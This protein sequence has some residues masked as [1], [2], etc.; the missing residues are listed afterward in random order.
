MASDPRG[1]F[2]EMIV[3]S[4]TLGMLSFHCLTREQDPVR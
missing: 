4:D 1:H 2:V 3:I